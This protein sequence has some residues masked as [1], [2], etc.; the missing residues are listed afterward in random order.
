MAK[1]I[2]TRTSP[3]LTPPSVDRGGPIPHLPGGPAGRVTRD[4]NADRKLTVV[5]LGF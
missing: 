4:V 2:D 1:S 5:P 3:T